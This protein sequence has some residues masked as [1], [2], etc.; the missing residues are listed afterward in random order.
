MSS[1][2]SRSAAHLLVRVAA[3]LTAKASDLF[4]QPL[5][6]E[7]VEVLAASFLGRCLWMENICGYLQHTKVIMDIAYR[8]N[9]V[10]FLSSLSHRLT[11]V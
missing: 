1:R 9:S 5:T 4:A 11:S 2:Q 8:H 6:I 7:K 10:F 3:A